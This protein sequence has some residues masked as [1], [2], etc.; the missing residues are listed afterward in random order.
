MKRNIISILFNA[1]SLW[2]LWYIL[3]FV[4]AL[5]ICFFPLFR[6]WTVCFV[7]IS[8]FVIWVFLCSLII[9]KLKK[10]IYII[11][12][13][14][15]TSTVTIFS[16]QIVDYQDKVNCNK[17]EQL[18]HKIEKGEQIDNAHYWFGLSIY[19]F[20]FQKENGAY[21]FLIFKGELGCLHQY[22]F[23]NKEWSTND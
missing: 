4:L 11:L 20:D 7:S 9:K 18:V 21:R 8:I 14:F 16:Q 13:I 22:D 23:K 6:K 17:A 19:S 10:Y 15:S 2:Y 3:D 12:F 1:V 5:E